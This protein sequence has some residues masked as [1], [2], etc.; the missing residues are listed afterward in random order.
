[1]FGHRLDRL[2][3]I[4]NRAVARARK[5]LLAV[6]AACAVTL[7][8]LTAVWYWLPGRPALWFPTS[9]GTSSN[10]TAVVV[11]G[12]DLIVSY[13]TNN[14]SDTSYLTFPGCPNCPLTL[15]AP[16]FYYDLNLTNNDT[17]AHR[18]LSVTLNSP[19]SLAAINPATPATLNP[20]AT[21]EFVLEIQAPTAPGTYTVSGTV[22]TS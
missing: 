13:W 16:T 5:T 19:F 18:L 2:L 11:D 6:A 7:L 17:L 22:N 9:G 21:T 12:V 14:S 3:T 1:V 20:G 4:R 10:G 8:L 15:S